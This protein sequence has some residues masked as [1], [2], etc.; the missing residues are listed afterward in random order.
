M[1][2]PLHTSGLDWR[3]SEF[4]NKLV[5]REQE[6]IGF[7]LL[8]ISLA[9]CNAAPSVSVKSKVDLS[10]FRQFLR[11][12]QLVIDNQQPGAATLFAGTFL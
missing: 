7:V 2:T 1:T 9:V 3:M 8:V 4:T 11:E 12:Y 5:S 10:P 6:M